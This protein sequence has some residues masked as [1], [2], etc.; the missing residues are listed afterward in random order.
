MKQQS[1]AAIKRYRT[2]RLASLA[3]RCY[4]LH[5]RGRDEKM[6]TLLCDEFVALGGVYIKF[7]QGIL[8][9]SKFL[10]KWQNPDRLKIFENLESE[11]LDI[12]KLLRHELPA[13]KLAKVTMIQPQPFAA[14]SFGQVYYGTLDNGQ[15]IIIKVLRPMVRELLRYDLRLLSTF[16][17][18]FFT[19]LYKNMNLQ[20]DD[21]LKEFRE[22]TLRETDY[23][24]EAKFANEM[25]VAYKDNPHL[26]IP[27]TYLELC[28][29]NIIVQDFVPGISAAQLIKLKEQGVDPVEYVHDNLGSDLDTQLRT[30]GYESMVGIFY[31]E[32]IQGDPHPG[33][34]RLMTDNRVGLIDFGISAKAPTEKAAFF[35]M[36]Q[37][38]DKLFKGSQTA[39][40]LFE[41]G[42]RFFVSDLYRALKKLA[43]IY[44]KGEDRDYL[45]EVS[46]IA[47]QAF[48][49]VT[50]SDIVEADFTQD[51][52][53]LSVINRLVNKG[54]RFGLIMRLESSD[55]LRAV[56]TYTSLV[57]SLGRY[58][59]V[60]P[61]IMDRA[62]RD[63]QKNYSDEIIDHD[64]QI[65][66]S[67]AIDIIMKWLERVAERDP[68]LFRQLMAKIKLGKDKPAIKTVKKEDTAHA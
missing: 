46:G 63:V 68:A 37:S 30:L 39:V 35:G 15:P 21:A 43:S 2:R 1:I 66:V 8:L 53:A 12:V 29:D 61:V 14:G 23:R 52:S 54:N 56:Q 40:G 58:Q 36:L 17:K 49:E 50:G 18:S 65:A 51:S 22:A 32:H 7:L 55:I 67:D 64:D 19:K 62:V 5:K 13:D 57:S 4:Y 20:V 31:L 44:G 48:A 34:I 45:S 10:R 9:R 25:Y 16:S 59:Q 11:P 3:T 26:L 38:Y 24:H 60:V 27:Q 33:N 41:Q 47:A 6:A 28:T 42:L